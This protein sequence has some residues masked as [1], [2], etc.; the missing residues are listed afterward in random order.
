[1]VHIDMP[2]AGR[3]RRLRKKAVQLASS[4]TGRAAFV[5]VGVVGL[6]AVAV[7]VLGPN[8]VRREVFEP[9]RDAV[10]PHAEKAWADTKPIRD[11]ITALLDNVPP[12]GAALPELAW[13]LRRWLKSSRL[14]C[15]PD[16]GTFPLPLEKP[17]CKNCLPSP[18]CWP[19]L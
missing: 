15:A 9:L 12:A 19:P 6:A 5:V 14:P 4:P 10:E 8:R 1:M 16:G 11:Q 7:A 3:R 17:A 18:P 13:S 2:P